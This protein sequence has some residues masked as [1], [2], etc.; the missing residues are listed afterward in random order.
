M[1]GFILRA[2]TLPVLFFA[3]L[4]VLAGPVQS[5]HLSLPPDA[6]SHRQVVVDIFTASYDVYR[7]YA[8]GQDEVAPISK[9]PL[10]PRNGWGASIVDGMSTMYI[11]GLED[12]FNDAV[13]FAQGI[14][15]SH[16]KT[17]DTVSLFESTIRYVAGLLSAYEL[18]GKKHPGLVTKAKQ[19]ADCLSLGWTNNNVIP[20]NDLDFKHNT[21]EN[22]GTSIAAAGTLTLEWSRLSLYTGNNT[23]RKLAEDA[24]LRIANNNAH[25]IA[26]GLPGQGLDPKTGAPT[27]AYVTWGGGS[28]SYFEYLIK[29]AR[30]SNT[31]DNTYADKWRLAVESSIKTLLKTSTVGDHV[32][33]ADY[34]DDRK[35]RHV[36]SHLACFHAGNWMLGGRL[37]NNETIV[38]IGLRL[39]DGCWNTY[40][41]T[42]TGIGPDG[43]AFAS[44]DGDYTG[45]QPPTTA[46]RAF[47]N[48]NG[49]Y[50]TNGYYIQRPEVLESNFYAWR[51]TGDTKYID[52]AASAV[53]SFQA[54]LRADGGYAGVE[55]VDS[56]QPSKNDETQSFWFAEVLK[57]LFLTFDDPGHIS[58]DDYVFNTEAHPFLAPPAKS[59]YG[60]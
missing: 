1:S 57:Y 11:M 16:S 26:A 28:D 15:F 49:F 48:K 7:K 42:A 19:L 41:S 55:D 37:L 25:V 14:D 21:F 60:S 46:Q 56:K 23:Y 40:S 38:N 43:F 50:I 36:S 22:T 44:A 4:A 20:Y 5:S 12:L 24:V 9:K 3:P 2:L 31:D 6:A 59:K 32:Y 45:E 33:L 13:N 10:N 47:Y 52:R 54:Y 35:I 17:A 58:L 39:N 53:R 8:W 30:L 27:D 29:Y 51:V 34:D 18:S